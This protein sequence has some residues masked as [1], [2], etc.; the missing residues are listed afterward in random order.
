MVI[1]HDD[2]GDDNDNTTMFDSVVL[3]GIHTLCVCQ[4]TCTRGYRIDTFYHNLPPFGMLLEGC[5]RPRL[6]SI[7][8]LFLLL[9]YTCV[10]YTRV[11]VLRLFLLFGGHGW[12][13]L[14][15]KCIASQRTCTCMSVWVVFLLA[16]CFHVVFLFLHHQ[17][18]LFVCS[19]G[20]VMQ[21]HVPSLYLRIHV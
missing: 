13:V 2:G 1:T 19:R 15:C 14:L 18:G 7:K 3:N 20:C 5:P 4:H 12:C 9:L 11:G 10:C 21:T 8:Q 6:F 17:Q 16:V